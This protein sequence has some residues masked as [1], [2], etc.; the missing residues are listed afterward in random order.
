MLRRLRA[1]TMFDAI[2]SP[3]LRSFELHPSWGPGAAQMGAFKDGE[4]NFFFAWFS[5]DGA[6]LRGFDH[7]SVM[8]PFRR[9]PPRPWPGLFDGLP[10]ALAYVLEEPAFALDEITF[11]FWTAGVSGGWLRGPV[12]LPRGKDVDG[13]RW[14]LA[15]LCEE[16]VRWCKRYD[17]P[18]SAKAVRA[19]W[20]EQEPLRL[21]VVIA[22]NPAPDLGVIREEAALLGYSTSGLDG[23][24]SVPRRR[25]PEPAGLPVGHAAAL[26][27]PRGFGSAEF[28]VRCE[29]TRVRMLIHQ[30]KVVVEA[31]VDVYEELF[32]LVKA[33]LVDAKRRGA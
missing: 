10:P 12:K 33:R 11:A 6:V 22:L 1:L 4:G 15:C 25:A 21:E 27:A 31:P 24:P 3:D 14:L 26:P 23:A 28:V 32:D 13:A 18:E 17:E 30:T 5:P 20:S 7:D 8:S 29:P 9:D 19:F 16:P 2:V